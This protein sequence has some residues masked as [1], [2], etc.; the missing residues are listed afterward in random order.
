MSE[1]TDLTMAAARKG[2]V[3]KEFSATEL[4][5]AHIE[6]IEA[7]N[8]A[9]NTFI[10]TTPELALA[11]ADVSD[12]KLQM[13][14]GGELEGIPLGIKDL[15]CT[16]GT[17]TTAGSHIL[18]GF[19]PTY[20]STISKNL[21]DAGGLMMGKLN[22]DEFAMGSSNETSY[23]GNCL[24][25]WKRNTDGANLV[26]GGSSGGSASRAFRRALLM[27]ATAT[28]TGGSIRQP[29]AFTGTVG[30]KPTYGRCSRWGVVAFASLAGSGGADHPHGGRCRHH[31]E[32][33]GQL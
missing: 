31:V 25:P 26:P 20:E 7:A 2:L 12:Q 9:L 8:E 29:A 15:F 24:S 11:L 16:M 30:M 10:V 13:G 22:L 17:Q 23:Y 19:T 3:D 18:D 32:G 5:E 6:A 27:G 4:C 14:I 33:H 1:L 21:L 28:D